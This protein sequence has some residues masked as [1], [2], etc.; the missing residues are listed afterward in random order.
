MYDPSYVKMLNA[1]HAKMQP[2]RLGYLRW[3][4]NV[5]FDTCIQIGIEIQCSLNDAPS[6]VHAIRMNECKH[7]NIRML[8]EIC[9]KLII[10]NR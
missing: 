4:M 7:A 2:S 6:P 9:P 1:T 10:K 3:H 8:I 5:T